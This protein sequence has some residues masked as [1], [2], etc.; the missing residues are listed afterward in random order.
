MS[1]IAWAYKFNAL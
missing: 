1:L